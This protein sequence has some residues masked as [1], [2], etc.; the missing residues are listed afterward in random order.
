[1][2]AG[3]VEQRGE[4]QDSIAVLLVELVGEELDSIVVLLLE[5]VDWLAESPYGY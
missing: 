2:P 4:E 5:S 3:G 1:M